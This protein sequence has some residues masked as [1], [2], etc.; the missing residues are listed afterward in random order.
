MTRRTLHSA[1]GRARLFAIPANRAE[2]AGHYVMGEADLVLVRAKRRA[3]DRLGFAV[4][5]RLLRHPGTGLGPGE[6]PPGAMLSFVAEQLGVPPGALAAYAARDQTRRG[7]AAELQAAL[8]LRSFRLADWRARLRVGAEAAWATDRGGP[9]VAAMLAHLR[10][11]GVVV[12]RPAVLER[13]PATTTGRPPPP[14]VRRSLS[15]GRGIVPPARALS[16]TSG[17]PARIA[18]HRPEERR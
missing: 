13:T 4:Q 14:C 5:L 17:G 10:Q 2:M 7:H 3:A 18:R 9:I 1:E 11:E 16:P 8:R 12:P 6:H 15:R